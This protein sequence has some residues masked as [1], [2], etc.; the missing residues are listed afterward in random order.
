[1]ES[2]EDRINERWGITDLFCLGK[3]SRLKEA[4]DQSKINY[5]NVFFD[6]FLIEL[7]WGLRVIVP[8]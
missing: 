8:I 1:V 4:A 6:I 7:A 5:K 3:I 2:K